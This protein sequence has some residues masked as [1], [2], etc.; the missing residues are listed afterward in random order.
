MNKKRKGKMARWKVP[1]Y[2]HETVVNWYYTVVE[3]DTAEEAHHIIQNEIANEESLILSG[4]KTEWEGC[5]TA[6]TDVL[7]IESYHAG[8]K[9]YVKPAPE[10]S[11]RISLSAFDIASIERNQLYV[12]AEQKFADN[13]IEIEIFEMEMIPVGADEDRVVWECIPFSRM[14]KECPSLWLERA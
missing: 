7:E 8:S 2:T 1:F 11:C 13:G 5:N 4:R 14:L 12:M 10:Y 9:D 6:T 3:A